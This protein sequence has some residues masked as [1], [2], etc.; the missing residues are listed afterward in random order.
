MS[1]TPPPVEVN[2]YQPPV[3]DAEIVGASVDAVA[4]PVRPRVWPVFV[5][6]LLCIGLDLLIVAV[7]LIVLAV[8][9]HAGSDAPEFDPADLFETIFESESTNWLVMGC[10]SL[11][12]A[13]VS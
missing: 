8:V 6:F 9:R 3:V 13:A 11:V 10:T 12:L 2:P 1:E 5:A 7:V 4:I